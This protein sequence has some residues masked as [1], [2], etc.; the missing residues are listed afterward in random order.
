[1]VKINGRL[2]EPAEAERVIRAVPGVRAAVVVPRTLASGR[3]QLVG[4][5]E[6]GAD[7]SVD[8]IRTALSESLPR[9]LTPA[10]LVR[11]QTLPLG[12]RGKLD[13]QLLRTAALSPWRDDVGDV[14]VSSLERSITDIAARC[15]EMNDL[16]PSD[17]LWAMGCD[18]LAA[19]EIAEA[20]SVTHDAIIQPNDLI[21]STTPRA[22]RRS[23]H[24][25]TAVGSRRRHHRQP[26]RFVDAAVPRGRRRG[27]RRA[28]PL[29]RT[30]PRA[31]PTR[32]HPRAGR[33]ASAVADRPQRHRRRA[34]TRRGHHAPLA[35]RSCRA[36]RP[37]L[38]RSRREPDGVDARSAWTRCRTDRA[39]RGASD[40]R[41]ASDAAQAVR[42]G[43]PACTSAHPVA[44]RTPPQAVSSC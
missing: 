8:A 40:R 14:P 39:R 22:H 12:D 27:A 13:R 16:A 5:V 24:R 17:D 21:S 20:I 6:A 4:H 32:G 1:M 25:C 42:L 9:S 7:V 29:P 11:H 37:F 2:V 33:A 26:T 44:A 19:V 41:A 28:V 34:T 30:R 3:Q 35:G 38:R 15:L 23:H 18:S 10:V 43:S 36:R 31:R